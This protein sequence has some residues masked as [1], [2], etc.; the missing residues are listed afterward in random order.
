M[1]IPLVLDAPKPRCLFGRVT[2]FQTIP[3]GASACDIQSPHS[4]IISSLASQKH[5]PLGST[6]Y[7]PTHR[8]VRHCLSLPRLDQ[9]GVTAVAPGWGQLPVAPDRP[10]EENRTA[11]GQTA[12]WRA[13]EATTDHRWN[14]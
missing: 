6:C 8:F 10:N 7:L 14:L 2:W 4:E 13:G 11:N 3:N 5:P 12:G 9:R 1:L